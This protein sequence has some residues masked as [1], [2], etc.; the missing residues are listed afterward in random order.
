MIDPIAVYNFLGIEGFNIHWYGVIVCLGIVMGVFVACR[1]AKTRGYH[2]DM[3]IDFMILALPLAVIGARLYY[4]AFEWER[5]AADPSKIIA[6]WEGG[7][8]I[9]GGIIGAVIAAVI[10]CKW[11]KIPFGDLFD[12]GGPGLVVGQIIGRWANFVNQEAFGNA[13]TNPSLQWFPY[14]VYIEKSHTI[15]DPAT[16]SWIVCEEPWHQATFFYESFW[17]VLVLVC[18]L[19]YFKRA[20]HKG[21]VFALYLALY[22][23]GRFIIEGMRTDSLWLIPG[24]IRVSQLVSIVLFIGGL[25]FIFLRHRKDPVKTVYKGKYEYKRVMRAKKEQKRK[26]ECK[27]LGTQYKAPKYYPAETK[28][29]KKYKKVAP[30]KADCAI[31]ESLSDAHEDAPDINSNESVTLTAQAEAADDESAKEEETNA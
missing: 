21:N 30:G 28:V 4:V 16:T 20:K 12:F 6:I 1:L 9:Y 14:S 18:L 7:L 24:V 31:N 17:N 22:G 5:Y 3:V 25:L 10:F 2:S 19:C 15:F 26:A 8:G 27:K 11:K 29:A 13:V 23:L